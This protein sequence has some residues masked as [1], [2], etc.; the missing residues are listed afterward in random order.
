MTNFTDVCEKQ[1]ISVWHGFSVVNTAP[2]SQTA[3]SKRQR[4]ARERVQRG[5]L[6]FVNAEVICLDD[7]IRMRPK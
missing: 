1:A 5:S 6:Y 2:I 7:D 3:Q 4:P